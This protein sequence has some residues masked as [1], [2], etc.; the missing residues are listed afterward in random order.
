MG[1]LPGKQQVSSLPELIGLEGTELDP[2]LVGP[3]FGRGVFLGAR[4]RLVPS[5]F[6]EV[7]RCYAAAFETPVAAPSEMHLPAC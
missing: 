4:F 2:W 1:L 3:E 6:S 7:R 5:Y